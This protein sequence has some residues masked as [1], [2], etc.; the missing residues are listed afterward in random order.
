MVVVSGMGNKSAE[1]LELY[2][3]APEKIPLAELKSYTY[4]GL[5][6]ADDELFRQM[7]Y[8]FAIVSFPYPADTT[9]IK[10]MG[11]I[12][13]VMRDTANRVFEKLNAMPDDDTYPQITTA[14]PIR[15]DGMYC[16]EV[17]WDNYPPKSKKELKE[18][19]RKEKEKK[20]Q[21]DREYEAKR[22]DITF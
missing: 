18:I 7:P 21:A 4:E 20:E 3:R 12:I 19:K 22:K 16:I 17:T 15:K 9:G 10:R 2:K 6:P 13:Y 14:C 8:E 5:R 1:A 11:K